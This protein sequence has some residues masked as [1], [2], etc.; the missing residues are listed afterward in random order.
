[1]YFNKTDILRIH[2]IH[3]SYTHNNTH[4]IKYLV[5]GPDYCVSVGWPSF[6]KNKDCQFNSVRTHAKVAGSVLSQGM[7]ERQPIDVSPYTDIS[8]PIFFPFFP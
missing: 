7:Y 4:R 1:M 5:S 8:L 6:P 3:S 2:I